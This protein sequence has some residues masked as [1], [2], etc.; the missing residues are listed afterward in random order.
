MFHLALLFITSSFLFGQINGIQNVRHYKN[1]KQWR[2]N[3]R[4]DLFTPQRFYLW[5]SILPQ[6]IYMSQKSP[7]MPAQIPMN[8]NRY[9]FP[10]MAA[11]IHQPGYMLALPTTMQRH[12]P[13]TAVKDLSEKRYKGSNITRIPIVAQELPQNYHIEHQQHDNLRNP[14]ESTQGKK[15]SEYPCGRKSMNDDSIQ[16]STTYY[17][18]I[19]SN[20]HQNNNTPQTEDLE[21]HLLPSTSPASGKSDMNLAKTTQMT[22]LPTPLHDVSKAIQPTAIITSHYTTFLPLKQNDNSI[23]KLKPTQNSPVRSGAQHSFFTIEDAI[24]KLT[25]MNQVFNSP[26]EAYRHAKKQQLY[27]AKPQQ[28]IGLKKNY[29]QSTPKS[30]LQN[31]FDDNIFE[32]LEATEDDF[33]HS[34]SQ[35]KEI[36]E[37]YKNQQNQQNK[38]IHGRTYWPNATNSILENSQRIASTESVP[39]NYF[40]S[41]PKNLSNKRALRTTTYPNSIEI[42]EEPVTHSTISTT[43]DY[44]NKVVENVFETTTTRAKH[45]VHTSPPTPLTT[46]SQPKFNKVNLKRPY[47]QVLASAQKYPKSLRGQIKPFKNITATSTSLPISNSL[48][49][50]PKYRQYKSKKNK[51]LKK[52][53][54]T[55]TSTTQS[56]PL[57]ETTE[58][59]KAVAA[60]TTTSVLPTSLSTKSTPTNHKLQRNAANAKRRNSKRVQNVSSTE[61][62]NEAVTNKTR[63]QKTRRRHSTTTTATISST[64][65]SL[66]TRSSATVSKSLTRKHHNSESKSRTKNSHSMTNEAHDEKQQQ[67]SQPKDGDGVPPLPI[68][69]YFKNSHLAKI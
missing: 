6:Q 62:S 57:E 55:A 11:P 18:N 32:S 38:I 31:F 60:I 66:S 19:Y 35:E 51:H 65:S 27:S 5:K 64:I 63:T 23:F 56:T 12:Y 68:E 49:K 58:K 29:N 69:I 67:V 33:S 54:P 46:P 10:H 44:P 15:E 30:F 42:F 2:P 22:F 16:I 8:Y 37:P 7:F 52:L 53:H 39:F 9:G 25:P 14:F 13:Y 59:M 34:E 24:T 21:E 28:G 61:K 48:Q 47:F 36:F 26:L 40:T 3:S 4:Q 20:Y 43:R 50:S 17:C 45:T 1:D 41:T